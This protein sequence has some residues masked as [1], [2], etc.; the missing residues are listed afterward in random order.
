MATKKA[1]KKSDEFQREMETVI[2]KL[3]YHA[4][5]VAGIQRNLDEPGSYLETFQKGCESCILDAIALILNGLEKKDL[6]YIL[7][8]IEGA[9][10][11]KTNAEEAPTIQ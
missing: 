11:V 9:K 1:N 8:R 7:A 2:D 10:I 6:I 5:F 3:G 4:V